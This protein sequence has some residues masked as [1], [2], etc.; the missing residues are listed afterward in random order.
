[1]VPLPVRV[2]VVVSVPAP[3]GRVKLNAWPPAAAAASL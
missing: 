1:M 3:F 2:T